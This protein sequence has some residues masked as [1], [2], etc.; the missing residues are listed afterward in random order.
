MNDWPA[1]LERALRLAAGAHHQQTRKASGL[2][3]I[4]HPVAVAMLLQ[5][6][7]FTDDETLA[8]A[9][10]H[11]VVEDTPVTLE[12]LAGEFPSA[13]VQLVGH[14]TER[15]QDESGRQRPWEDRKREHLAHIA[16]APLAARAIALADK[17]HNLRTM[18]YDLEEGQDLSMRFNASFGQLAWYYESMI[19]AAAGRDRELQGLA[20]AARTALQE[21]RRRVEIP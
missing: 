15:K 14:L 6:H 5:Q 1:L 7:G 11:D 2:P 19:E 18:S 9:L 12:D 8:A 20:A 3:Y 10:L 16:D 17:L 4:T 21:V 13:V